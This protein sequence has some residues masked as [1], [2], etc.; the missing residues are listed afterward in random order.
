MSYHMG[1]LPVVGL[2]EQNVTND[3]TTYHNSIVGYMGS[4][5]MF[6]YSWSDSAGGAHCT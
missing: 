3:S 2:R 1:L 5:V 6:L 4:V